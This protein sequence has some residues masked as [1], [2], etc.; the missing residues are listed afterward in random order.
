M[1]PPP[2]RHA[3]PGAQAGRRKVSVR[4]GRRTVV[5]GIPGFAWVQVC[6]HPHRPLRRPSHDW[7][8]WPIV[9]R[10]DYGPVIVLTMRS[11]ALHRAGVDPAEPAV[12]PAHLAH[13]GRAAA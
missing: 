9:R 6:L 13:P 8:Y 4:W 7:L 11:D 12:R 3:V 1:T 5:R 10:H 2:A